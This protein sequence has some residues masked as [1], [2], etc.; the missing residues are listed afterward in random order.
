MVAILSVGDQLFYSFKLFFSK[1]G[2]E[3]INYFP[4]INTQAMWLV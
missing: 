4:Q 2:M 1:Y 3:L